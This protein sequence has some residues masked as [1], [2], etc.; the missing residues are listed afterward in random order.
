[1]KV[2][3]DLYPQWV[4]IAIIRVW[5]S[6]VIFLGLRQEV[7]AVEMEP[8]VYTLLTTL[9]HADLL[10]CFRQSNWVWLLLND[11]ILLFDIFHS[12]FL[13]KILVGLRLENG[14]HL[15]YLFW[16]LTNR[17]VW[18]ERVYSFFCFV[19]VCLQ[20]YLRFGSW[21]VI[22]L[23]VALQELSWVCLALSIIFNFSLER[24]SNWIQHTILVLHWHERQSLGIRFILWVF[25]RI[26]NG[27]ILRLC[28]QQ[29]LTEWARLDTWRV[30]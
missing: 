7:L 29:P 8:R 23:W 22:D 14:V 12:L 19:W 13:Q 4:L 10:H 11:Q 27:R 20:V 25:Q 6:C 5:R 30:G 21:V 28:S 2:S 15:I 24:V 9:L 3:L 1:M 16:G 18:L 17:I 26:S